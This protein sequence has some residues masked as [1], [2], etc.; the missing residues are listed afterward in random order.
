MPQY[1][2]NF[3]TQV[4]LRADFQ[5]DTVPMAQPGEQLL[6][7]LFNLRK[8]LAAEKKL[9]AYLIFNDATLRE[10]CARKP[11]SRE[12]LLSVKGVGE[13]KADQYGQAFLRLVREF[14]EE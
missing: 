7:A 11:Q 8:R 12:E 9:P 6:A 1:A 5:T 14:C 3:I 4:I 10:I 13:V 2:K